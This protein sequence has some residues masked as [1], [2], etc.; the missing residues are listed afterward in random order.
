MKT[1]SDDIDE[2]AR[3]I[4]ETYG[5]VLHQRSRLVKLAPQDNYWDIENACKKFVNL[6]RDGY[7]ARFINI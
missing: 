2:V 7:L 4:A 1:P 3:H 5:L 6:Y